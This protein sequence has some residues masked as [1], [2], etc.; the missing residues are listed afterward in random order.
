MSY[1]SAGLNTEP[2]YISKDKKCKYLAIPPGFPICKLKPL[3]TPTY[4]DY[5]IN[6]KPKDRIFLYTD[7][8]VEQQSE[9]SVVYTNENLFEM[10]SKNTTLSSEKIFTI[11][12]QGISVSQDSISNLKDDITYLMAEFEGVS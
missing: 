3:Y 12:E 11:L 6:V 1:S 7:G 10:I 9:S 4:V 8:L 5:M 2:I